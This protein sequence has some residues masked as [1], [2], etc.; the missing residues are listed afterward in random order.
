MQDNNLIDV[1]LTSEM[2]T[3][4]IDYA[5]SVIVSRALP[6]VRDGLKPVQRRILY[7]MNELGVTP[8]KPHKKSARITGD[9]MGNITHTGT[10]LSMKPWFVWHNGGA[11]V[12][13]WL[14]VTGTLVLWTEMGLPL[15]VILK[16]VCLKSLGNAT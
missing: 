11:T 1:N 6:D 7:G 14:M 10:H 13:C 16:R 9:V 2:K 12:T 8:D 4:F 3:S 5:M 15:S